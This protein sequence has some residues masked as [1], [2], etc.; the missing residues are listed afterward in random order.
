MIFLIWMFYSMYEMKTKNIF[1]AG[2]N[3]IC[4]QAYQLQLFHRI[5]PYLKKLILYEFS[6]FEFLLKILNHYLVEVNRMKIFFCSRIL[7][8]IRNFIFIG[9][10]SLFYNC[11][12]GKT[13]IRLIIPER[14]IFEGL[15]CNPPF[16]CNK[17]LRC[18]NIVPSSLYVWP[19]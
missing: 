18:C 9:N 14:H 12:F 3:G 19:I 16:M 7:T 4:A 11:L 13:W 8:Q 17:T 6:F 2:F 10:D 1:L 5:S 15:M